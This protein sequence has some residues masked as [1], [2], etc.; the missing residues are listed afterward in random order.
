ML[1]LVSTLVRPMAAIAIG[2]AMAT[3]IGSFAYAQDEQTSYASV[4]EAVSGLV[5]A[6]ASND[7]K[8][9][10]VRV[11]G[12]DGEAIATS[13]DPVADEARLARFLNAFEEGHKVEQEDASKAILLVGTDEFPFPIPIVADNGKWRWDTAQGLE[14]I[15]TRRI[16]E[17]E[18]ATI[19]VML[20]YVAAQLEY[21]EQD[22]DGKGLQYARRLMSREGRKDGLY[23][24]VAEGEE[25]SPMGP[26]VAQAQR[27]GYSGTGTGPAYN[28]YVF[29]MLHGQGKNASDGARDYIV[30]DRMIGGFALIATPAEYGNSG[31]MTFIVNQD[32]NVYEKDLGPNSAAVAARIKLFDPDPSWKRVESE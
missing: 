15:L 18:L 28:G 20:A 17:N 32:G 14:E 10:I 2:F 29:R 31:V 23:W 25:P 9:A 19:E 5:D 13:G 11:L 8:Q 27:K 30:N 7:A 26:L 16:G 4:E 6:V 12:P 21:A 3:S 22:R 1:G 24:V